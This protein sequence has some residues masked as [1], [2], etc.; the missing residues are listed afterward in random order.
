M[1]RPKL[2][3]KRTQMRVNLTTEL[4]NKIK[5]AAEEMGVSNTAW[6]QMILTN[7]FKGQE[8]LRT[9]KMATEMAEKEARKTKE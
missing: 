5:E 6:M 4:M 3:G 9:L 7:H 2:T 8:G 1:A